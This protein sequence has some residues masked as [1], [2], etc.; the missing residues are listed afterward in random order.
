MGAICGSSQ[1]GFAPLVGNISLSARGTVRTM[2]NGLEGRSE[3]TD[4]LG[5]VEVEGVDYR[6]EQTSW[7]ER[8]VIR[9][10]DGRRVGKL[11]GSPALMWLLEAELIEVE[12][13]RS[14]VHA[15]IEQGVL[16]DLP[17]D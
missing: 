1:D 4:L 15:A 13:L 2:G 11:R 9:C 7:N 14:I 10:E 8:H 6:I 3:P 16:V 12:L 5:K 17:T